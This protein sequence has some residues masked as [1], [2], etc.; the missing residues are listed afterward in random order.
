MCHHIWPLINYYFGNYR[1][2]IAVRRSRDSTKMGAVFVRVSVVRSLKSGFDVLKYVSCSIDV[3]ENACTRLFGSSRW[4]SSKQ[5]P[6]LRDE[7]SFSR[8]VQANDATFRFYLILILVTV[9]W[10]RLW[11]MIKQVFEGLFILSETRHSERSH[12]GSITAAGTTVILHNVRVC[13]FDSRA[14][15]H[16]FRRVSY[17]RGRKRMWAL[18]LV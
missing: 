12:D 18:S 15:F 9:R 10:P 13:E 1:G 11:F 3:V 2:A 5:I 8:F 4:S 17:D 14:F 6:Y 7:L 16:D